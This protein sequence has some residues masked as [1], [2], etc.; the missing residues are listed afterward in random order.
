M[1]KPETAEMIARSRTVTAGALFEGRA[2]LNGYPY[3]LL[4]VVQEGKP[5]MDHVSLVLAAAEML[6]P[7]GWQLVNVS[8]FS[9][10]GHA[11]AVMQRRAAISFDQSSSIG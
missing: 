7:Y 9:Q 8:E 5:G 11:C 3:Q 1:V 2:D 6:L 4:G 10:N